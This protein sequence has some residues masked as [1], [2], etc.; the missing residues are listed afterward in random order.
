MQ[1]I[2]KWEK[3]GWTLR[4]CDARWKK[5][6]AQRNVNASISPVSR[7]TLVRQR[8]TSF[9][10]H[11]SSSSIDVTAAYNTRAEN[12]LLSRQSSDLFARSL[13]NEIRLMR[14]S[15]GSTSPLSALCGKGFRRGGRV[16]EGSARE[17]ERHARGVAKGK[18]IEQ[19]RLRGE[20]RALHD[21][22]SLSLFRHSKSPRGH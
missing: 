1:I 19:R 11:S 4:S 10:W 5:I 20:A 16:E 17:R 9:P 22:R 12:E 6:K 7:E 2:S 3:K 14:S 13:P 21:T 18:R 15:D 8:S